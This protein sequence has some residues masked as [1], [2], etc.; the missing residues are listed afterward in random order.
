VNQAFK[1]EGID[2]VVIRN[3]ATHVDERGWLCELFRSDEPELEAAMAY[4]SM[5][6]PGIT[7]GPH[8][9][10]TQTDSFCFVGPSPM[11]LVLWDNRPSSDTHGHRMRLVTDPA[12]PVLVIVPPGVVH[13][14]RNLGSEPAYVVN[15]PDQLYRGRQRL[16]PADEI[17]HETVADS[18]FDMDA[19]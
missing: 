1:D 17:R 4:V 15:L 9:H 16:Q 19:S 8:E 6:R 7:R 5:T 13:G 14:Y 12:Q 18:P 2:G 3:L 11:L 10:A